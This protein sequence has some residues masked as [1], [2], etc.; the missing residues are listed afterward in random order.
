MIALNHPNLRRQRSL[1]HL[2]LGNPGT[3]GD[4]GHQI[5]E[6]SKPMNATKTMTAVAA[7]ALASGCSEAQTPMNWFEKECFESA[8]QLDNKAVVY[9]NR[10]NLEAAPYDNITFEFRDA[11]LRAEDCALAHD[12][13]GSIRSLQ[14]AQALFDSG[15]FKVR[16]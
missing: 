12:L 1:V 13:A 3:K 8:I 4:Y 7:F 15:D 9:A 6:T 11:I 14:K 16:R 5:L 2:S 10:G